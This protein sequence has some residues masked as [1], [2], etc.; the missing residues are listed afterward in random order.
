MIEPLLKEPVP[1]EET[2]A[3]LKVD[4][5]PAASGLHSL[6]SQEAFSASGPGRAIVIAA[7]GRAVFVALS[8]HVSNVIVVRAPIRNTVLSV[9]LMTKAVHGSVV[10]IVKPGL[11]RH[12][13]RVH[14][15]D[16]MSMMAIPPGSG[17]TR[18]CNGITVA[19]PNACT[20]Q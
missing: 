20:S 2:Q 18:H 8:T 4:I 14:P 11:P 5:L 15:P 12:V 17:I 19:S 1:D 3:V 13:A 9:R 16:Q 7:A 6:G 10:I